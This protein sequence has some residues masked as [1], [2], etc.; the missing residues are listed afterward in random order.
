MEIFDNKVC[1]E[2]TSKICAG[3]LDGDADTCR[4]SEFHVY[5]YNNLIMLKYREI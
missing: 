2:S 4:V 3:A 1:S 5:F